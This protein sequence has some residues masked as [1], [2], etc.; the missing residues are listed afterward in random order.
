MRGRHGRS[1]S[2][3]IQALFAFTG[4]W[5]MWLLCRLK[6]DRCLEELA[7]LTHLLA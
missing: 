6:D 1:L 5:L 7:G 3:T 2:E 4:G